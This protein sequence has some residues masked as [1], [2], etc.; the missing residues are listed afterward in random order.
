M[1]AT[2]RDLPLRLQ[3]CPA[4]FVPGSSFSSSH[5]QPKKSDILNQIKKKL[6]DSPSC[7][8]P[9]SPRVSPPIP[10]FREIYDRSLAPKEKESRPDGA[11]PVTYKLG[12]DSI[13]K[14]LNRLRESSQGAAQGKNHNQFSLSTLR[15]NLGLRPGDLSPAEKVLP[16]GSHKFPTSLGDKGNKDLKGGYDTGAVEDSFELPYDHNELGQKLIKLRPDHLG[17]KNWFSLQEL[18]DRLL[19]V[20]EIAKEEYKA[21]NTGEFAMLRSNLK[22]I[23]KIGTDAK[24]E[25]SHYGAVDITR[26]FG[27]KSEYLSHPPKEHLVEKYFDPA[28]MSSAEKMKLELKK[29]RDEFKMTESDCGSA[30][31]QVAQLTTKIKHLSGVLHK[32]DKHSRKGLK[33]MV[34]KRKKM[35]K[36]L[37]RTDWD[38]YCLVLSKLGLPEKDYYK[39]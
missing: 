35:L 25:N 8:A 18:N 1:A 19:K 11:K 29:V 15:G 12:L 27:E 24:N 7:S 26:L 20:R 10:S 36:Y 33:A 3:R 28:L 39:E 17:N 32:K 34:E 37:R 4:N 5:G 21:K 9:P 13:A 6:A 16:I 31:V 30:R 2:I 38:S 14:N 23:E 22:S